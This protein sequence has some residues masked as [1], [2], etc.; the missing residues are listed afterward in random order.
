LPLPIATLLAWL[1]QRW[2]I[3]VAHPE[4]KTGLGLGE[5]QCWNKR[6]TILSLQWTVWVYAILLL[7]GY[8]SWGLCSGPPTPARWWPGAKRCSLSTLW[9]SYP[10]DLWNL[11]KFRTLCTTS[12]ND[13]WNIQTWLPGLPNSA[14]AASRIESGKRFFLASRF[15]SF[16]RLWL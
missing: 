2:K 9:P 4:M 11:S 5:K 3:E 8:R 14:S 16:L 1:W 12:R 13:W 15:I 6:S 7:A 10:A